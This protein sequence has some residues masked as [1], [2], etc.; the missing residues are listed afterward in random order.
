MRSYR[1]TRRSFL[2]AVGGAVG[3]RVMLSNFEAMA[4]GATGSPARFLLTHF[5]VGTMRHRYLPEGSGD[6]YTPSQILEPFETAGLRGD[7]TI[8]YGF[9][10]NHLRCPG[11][12]GHEAGTP[13][14]TTCTNAEGTRSNGGEGD[15]GTAGGPSFDQIFLEKVPG[16]KQPGAGYANAICDA[17]V[18]SNETS[19]QCLSYGY[20]SRSIQSANPGGNITEY[21]P[22]LPELS[23]AKLYANLFSNFMPG[24]ASEG[25]QEAAIDALRRKKSVLDFSMRELD[26]LKRIIPSAEAPKIDVHTEAIRK[27]EQQLAMQIETGMIDPGTSC[28]LPTAP[29]EDLTG[30]EGNSP[31][32]T[33][34]VQRDDSPTHRE[35]ALAHSGLLL[36]AFQCDLLRVATFQFSPGTN[37]VSFKGFWPSDPNRIAMHHPVSHMNPFLSGAASQEPPTSGEAQ[38]IYEFLCNVQV[39]YNGLMAEILTNFKNATD[40]FGNS[41]LDYTVIPYVTEVSEPSHSRSPKPGLLFGGT[42]LGMKHGTFQNFQQQRPQVDLY[43][44]AAQALLQTSDV[45]SALEGELFIDDNPN[46]SVIPDLWEAPI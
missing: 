28:M 38:D 17:R 39:W 15:D 20:T 31:Y 36:T 26:E 22:L 24:G 35:V 7:M 40:A 1:L 46:A 12:G 2:S 30:S 29:S 10:D 41:I 4:L 27:I 37:H 33:N 16:M 11:G 32:S 43:L 42:A 21:T 9:S 45:L 25:N 8:F 14:T 5:P 34:N 13:F 6:S 18:D 23:P 19:T 44:T 3:L